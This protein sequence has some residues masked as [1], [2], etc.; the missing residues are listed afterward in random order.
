M[1]HMTL[2]MVKTFGGAAYATRIA[3]KLAKALGVL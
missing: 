3:N 1:L 2:F